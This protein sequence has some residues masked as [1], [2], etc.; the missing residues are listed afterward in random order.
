MNR[1]A[2]SFF[3]V[4]LGCAAPAPTEEQSDAAADASAKDGAPQNK[5]DAQSG[6][7]ASAPLGDAATLDA[8]SADEPDAASAPQAIVF[9]HTPDTLYSFDPTTN[10]VSLVGTF[11]GCSQTILTQV[12]DLAVDSQMN[13]FATTFDGFYSVD[14]TTAQCTLVKTGSYPNSLSFVPAGTLD[15]NVEALVGYFGSSYVRIDTS[16]GNT[17]VIGTLSGG[18]ASSGDVVSVSGGG[19]YLT[20]TG[21]GCGDCLLQVDPTTG[22]VVQNFGALPHGEVY[23]LGYWAGTLFGFDGTGD[24][25]SIG[26]GGDAGLVTS[27]VVTNGGVTWWGAGSTT[28]APTH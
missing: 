5:K 16:S 7:D 23:G 27:D 24:L 21:N 9:G 19:T 17:T 14:L 18:Y 4:V 28:I 3:V 11:S 13:A 26:T 12:I 25:F 1:I 6:S 2:L 15:P 8:Q 10:N 20:V 22:D